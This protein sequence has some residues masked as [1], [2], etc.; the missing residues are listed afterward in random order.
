MPD[1]MVESARNDPTGYG[2]MADTPYPGDAMHL[3]DLA[4]EVPPPRHAIAH[5]DGGHPG[6]LD[7]P[8]D[9]HADPAGRADPPGAESA[10]RPVSWTARTQAQ[11]K[12]RIDIADAVMEKVVALAAHEAEGVATGTGIDVRL[13]NREVAIG[14]TVTVEFGHVVVEV[15]REVKANIAAAC[16]RMLG[17][18]VIEVN[19]GVDDVVMSGQDARS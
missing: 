3:A 17:L 16:N 6:R 5:A 18:R 13:Q 19:V 12:G 14:L 11:V 9:P 10:G 7:A 8:V 1:G 2:V 15:A 4:G